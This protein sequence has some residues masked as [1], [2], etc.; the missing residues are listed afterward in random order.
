MNLKAKRTNS[1]PLGFRLAGWLLALFSTISAA[2][3]LSIQGVNRAEFWQYI[4]FGID[5]VRRN[6]LQLDSIRRVK[7][8]PYTIENKLDLKARYGDINGNLGLMLF[9]PS[10]PW[11]GIRQPLRLLDYTLAYS[12]KRFEILL[13]QFYQTFG[14][15]LALRSF[16]DD[17]FRHYKSLHGIR[18][19]ARL[20]YKSELT[21][22]GARLRD[23]FFEANTYKLRNVDD[24]S[25]QVLGADLSARP[26]KYFGFGG[27]YVRLNR[28][29]DMTP[30]AFTE[31]YGGN[32]LGS[33]GP[34]ELQ[35]EI[36]QR[37]GTRPGIGGREKGLGYY[38]NGTLSAGNYSLVG[39]YMDYDHLAVPSALYHYNDPPTPIQSGVVIN[40]GVDEK[41]FGLTTSG[42][43]V[44]PL[45]IQGYYG[46]LFTHDNT[47]QG[48]YEYEGKLRYSAGAAWTF[49]AKYNNLYTR[50][51]ELHV[52]ER[53][54]AKPVFHANWTGGEHMVAFEAEYGFVR[55]QTDDPTQLEPWRY[56][57]L[58]LVFSYGYGAHLLF[59]FGYQHVDK[60]LFRRYNDET[61]WPLFETVWSITDRNV[62]RVRIGAE[63]GGYTC[64]GGVCRFEAPF[65][66]IKAQLISRF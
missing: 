54:V 19:I 23:V 64:S 20:P 16:S 57:E 58:A 61:D 33:L 55:E 7:D 12:P 38:L 21:L 49:E 42:T 5:T 34:V 26:S 10:K 62:L 50:A 52:N 14:K 35:G 8:L 66:G 43:P 22:L 60:K 53:N 3:T 41:G 25:D 59:T 28:A 46:R 37:L 2:P 13:G 40:T 31:L 32:L 51:I 30:R 24:S 63:R 36:C 39:E 29:I 18:G 65:T 1:R 6:S 48:V 4:V 17:D 56:H 45:F 9:E 47:S 44:G 15:G 27:R 11:A